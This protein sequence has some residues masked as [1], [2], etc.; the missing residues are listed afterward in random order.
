MRKSQEYCNRVIWSSRCRFLNPAGKNR[1][2]NRWG[3]RQ[4]G[5]DDKQ[6][7]GQGSPTW[8]CFGPLDSRN[9][10]L[11]PQSVE[12]GH[13]AGGCVWHGAVIA[14]VDGLRFNGFQQG[15]HGGNELRHAL[16]YKWARLHRKTRRRRLGRVALLDPLQPVQLF[17]FTRCRGKNIE[18]SVFVKQRE[19]WGCR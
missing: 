16:G 1:S 15:Q 7:K 6:S 10:L 14:S 13:E 12:R 3:R 9:D 19:R 18:N 2:V 5:L 11:T 4:Q 17:S 8:E